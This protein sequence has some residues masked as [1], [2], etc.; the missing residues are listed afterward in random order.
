M[1]KGRA[2]IASGILMFRNRETYSVWG[3]PDRRGHSLLAVSCVQLL[4]SHTLLAVELYLECARL[5]NLRY[6]CIGEIVN[7]ELSSRQG[8]VSI[9]PILNVYV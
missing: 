1:P 4:C 9:G 3:R 5:N 7:A 8:I 2:N 6:E